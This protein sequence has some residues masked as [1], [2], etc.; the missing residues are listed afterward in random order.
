MATKRHKE[1]SLT[2][3]VRDEFNE[4]EFSAVHFNQKCVMDLINHTIAV[5]RTNQKYIILEGMCN[6]IK[7]TNDA[8]KYELRLQDELND[9]EQ[10]I[11]EIQSMIGLQFSYE[12]EF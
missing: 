3:Q 6:S 7:L 5:N 12:P 4:A 11:G 1:I 8:D 2:T 10:N 9:I